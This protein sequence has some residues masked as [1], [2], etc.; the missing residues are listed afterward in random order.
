MYTLNIQDIYT[1]ICT[2]QC[3]YTTTYKIYYNIYRYNYILIYKAYT[4]VY[5][6]YALL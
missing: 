4:H 6:K 5:V 3:I 1:C 2:I